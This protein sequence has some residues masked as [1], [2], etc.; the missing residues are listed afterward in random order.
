MIKRPYTRETLSPRPSSGARSRRASAARQNPD[1]AAP[2]ARRAREGRASWCN[3]TSR[4]ARYRCTS[5]RHA[6]RAARARWR[7]VDG[8][9]AN[10]DLAVAPD[11]SAT[12]ACA[13]A[14]VRGGMRGGGI[15]ASPRREHSRETRASR[16]S[17]ASRRRALASRTSRAR[18]ARCVGRV[19]SRARRAGSSGAGAPSSAAWRMPAM[20]VRAELTRRPTNAGLAWPARRPRRRPGRKRAPAASLA[21]RASR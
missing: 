17:R 5:S 1:T 12:T 21:L 13:I 9:V 10:A 11:L 15:Y 4:A 14:H 16:R 8:S 7:T 6:P 18:A 19:S 20:M 2:R 3:P